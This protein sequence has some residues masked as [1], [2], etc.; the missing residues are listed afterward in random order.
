[1]PTRPE[2][3]RLESW[4]DQYQPKVYKAACLVLR[5]PVAAQD[6]AQDT[7]L[8]AWNAMS[9][10]EEGVNVER[11]LCRISINLCL[12]Q[13]R[14][15]RREQT[16]VDRMASYQPPEDSYELQ[17][18]RSELD[19]AL[20]RLPDRLRVPL[21]LRYYL[22]FSE[23]DI[24]KALSLRNGTVKSRLHEARRLLANDAAVQAAH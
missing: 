17:A 22:D 12:N 11:W 2:L 9:R 16:A 15:R 3:Q 5:D 21:I 18:T 24:A 6:V 13:I 19:E 7:F 14:S 20:R 8:R 1:M 23:T 4:I 10:V